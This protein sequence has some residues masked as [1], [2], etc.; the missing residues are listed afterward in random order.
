[1]V[2]LK[3]IAA[4]VNV[5]TTVVS[6]VLNNPSG[7]T[8]VSEQTR[9]LIQKV[10][11]EMNYVPNRRAQALVT[12]RTQTIG[13]I[14]SRTYVKNNHKSD[15]YFHAILHGV[16]ETCRLAGYHCLY[17]RYELGDLE[18]IVYPQSMKDGSVDGVV[19]AGYTPRE[20][21]EKLASLRLPC[22]QVGTNVDPNC[23]IRC[24]TGDLGRAFETVARRLR[25]LGHRRIQLVLPGGPGPEA[26]AK[27]F[28]ELKDRIAGL[29]PE[30]ALM[31]A[32]ASNRDSALAHAQ[33]VVRRARSGAASCDRPT[34]FICNPV[35]STGLAEGL[36]EHGWLC[37]R[38]YSMVCFGLPESEDMRL[39]PGNV[40]L[41]FITLPVEDAGRLAAREL[42]KRLGVSVPAPQADLQTETIKSTT[43]IPCGV[44]FRESCGAV[45]A[46][47]GEVG[48]SSKVPAAAS[49]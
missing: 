10:A 37:P 40:R 3:D 26:W 34:A 41:S 21:I 46:E 35:H 8:R 49:A 39:Y 36:A 18:H 2:T 11:R 19:L 4:R 30:I 25:E 38:D 42:L 5:S 17:A 24:F 44:W 22:V 28:V 33:T 43:Y 16:E 6:H 1:M 7:N 15:A 32:L 27:K 47:G 20:A 23:G 29:E 48:S 12:R 31:P 14:C 9:K 45:A 13:F